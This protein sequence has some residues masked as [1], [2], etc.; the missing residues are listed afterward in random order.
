[1]ALCTPPIFSVEPGAKESTGCQESK[2]PR[3]TANWLHTKDP[4]PAGPNVKCGNTTK[5]WGFLMKRETVSLIVSSFWCG[6]QDSSQMEDWL[7]SQLDQELDTERRWEELT[8]SFGKW[9]ETQGTQR[10]VRYHACIASLVAQ[11]VKH[12][13]AMTERLHF[14]SLHFTSLHFM[15]VFLTVSQAI[16]SS[17]EWHRHPVC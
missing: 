17:P 13:P 7:E 15:P 10:V 9:W 3:M 12:L 1:M 6:T 14:T 5:D 2:P 11:T 4:L 16:R 8:H